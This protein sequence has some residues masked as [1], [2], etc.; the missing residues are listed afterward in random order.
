MSTINTQTNIGNISSLDLDKDIVNINK[1]EKKGKKKKIIL[2]ISICALILIIAFFLIYF[3]IIKKKPKPE[4]KLFDNKTNDNNSIEALYS[5]QEGK[6]IS[7][8][9]PKEIN[10]NDEDYSIEEIDILNE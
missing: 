5:V 6:K 8:F 7:L 9:N 1:Q 10:L 2:I 4:P 3:L